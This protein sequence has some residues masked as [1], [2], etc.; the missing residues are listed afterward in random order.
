MQC[1][2]H[3]LYLFSSTVLHEEKKTLFVQPTFSDDNPV[4]GA[5]RSCYPTRRNLWSCNWTETG[6]RIRWREKI[7]LLLR[8]ET[9]VRAQN[10]QVFLRFAIDLCR[11]L[12]TQSRWGCSSHWSCRFWDSERSKRRSRWTSPSKSW[13]A[14]RPG[15][16]R[17][18][19]IRRI[20]FRSENF[21]I[22]YEYS[23]QP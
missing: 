19:V 23:C 6:Q 12:T 7:S 3:V 13:T 8:S 1:S 4:V 14:R 9:F 21:R 5:E 15:Y 22:A 18:F 20:D 10:Q 16:F 17:S 2:I 11:P